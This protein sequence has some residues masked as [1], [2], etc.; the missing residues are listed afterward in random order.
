MFEDLGIF[1]TENRGWRLVI[2]GQW[3][4]NTMAPSGKMWWSDGRTYVG[5]FLDGRKHGEGTLQL[6]SAVE[7]GL[8]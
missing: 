3:T 5:E 7:I 4:H 2:Q 6:G 1:D 8:K